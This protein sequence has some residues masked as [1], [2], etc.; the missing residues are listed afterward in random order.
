V[1]RLLESALDAVGTPPAVLA[2]G[3]PV[4]GEWLEP[5]PEPGEGPHLRLRLAA[6][7]RNPVRGTPAVP[8]FNEIDVGVDHGAA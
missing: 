5:A 7:R 1:A 3:L 6:W 2:G 4:R 8:P